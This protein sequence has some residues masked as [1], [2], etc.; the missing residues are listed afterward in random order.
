[1]RTLAIATVML[2]CGAAMP[3]EAGFIFTLTLGPAISDYD[4]T[5]YSASSFSFT[6]PSIPTLG[7]GL[8]CYNFVHGQ[9]GAD[10]TG[11]QLNGL[12]IPRT[13]V[14]LETFGGINYADLTYVTSASLP[15]GA[16]GAFQ[17][18]VP[19]GVGASL[20]P[21]TYSVG[22]GGTGLANRF[23]ADQCVCGNYFLSAVSPT[24]SLTIADTPEPASVGLISSGLLA[25][26]LLF[27]KRSTNT[28]DSLP[29]PAPG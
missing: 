23:Q 19:L 22:V 27:R 16:L 26:T 18:L 4:G 15:L 17:L 14:S 13:V 1:M 2:A 6:A 11:A 28:P 10:F 20:A 29:A 12:P 5:V 21:G 8:C 24:G 3:A 25:L 7:G 9:F